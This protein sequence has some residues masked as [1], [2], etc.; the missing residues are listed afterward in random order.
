MPALS[1]VLLLIA[2]GATILAWLVEGKRGLHILTTAISNALVVSVATMAFIDP[3]VT[4]SSSVVQTFSLAAAAVIAAAGGGPLTTVIFGVI[5][6][7]VPDARSMQH[8]GSVL[9]GGAWIGVLER[10]AVFS[11]LVA[12]WPEGLAVVLGLKGVGRYPELRG[13]EG[14]GASSGTAERFIIGTFSSVLWSAACAGVT[15]LLI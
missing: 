10:V 5:D 8:A 9:R 15:L 3:E 13:T 11:T 14:S 6:G 12:G 7:Y 2:S 4:D 1:L